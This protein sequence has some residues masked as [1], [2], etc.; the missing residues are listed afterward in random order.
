MQDAILYKLPNGQFISHDPNNVVLIPSEN[1]R[2]EFIKDGVTS[3]EFKVKTSLISYQLNAAN[4]IIG[5]VAT[6]EL[7]KVDESSTGNV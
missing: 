7:D 4:E 1:G 3:V 5:A 2:V 6:I